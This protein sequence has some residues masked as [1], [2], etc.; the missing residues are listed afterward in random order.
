MAELD[1]A[2]PRLRLHCLTVEEGKR[3]VDSAAGAEDRWAADFPMQDDRDGVGGYLH[4][5]SA[6][7]DPAPFGC[8]RID[9][10][11]VAIGTI[12]FFGPPDDEGRVTIGY[13]LVP[14]ARQF[15]YATEAV[16]RLV[17]L[18]RSHDSVRAMLAD[19]EKANTASQRVLDKTGFAFVREDDESRYYQVD[20]SSRPRR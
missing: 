17:D 6:G 14:A 16:G 18:C 1:L 15:G 13:G 19:T 20:V 2:T 11:G 4:N 3:I 9:R 12:G 5:A 8:Y 10:D 7:Q